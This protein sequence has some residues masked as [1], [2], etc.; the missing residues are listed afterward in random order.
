MARNRARRALPL[1]PVEGRRRLLKIAALVLG[2]VALL[3]AGAAV[4]AYVKLQRNIT[5]V[6]VA[7]QL[8]TERPESPSASPSTKRT[9]EGPLTV[10][11]FGDDTRSGKNGFVGGEKGKGRSD[12]ALVVHLNAARTRAT[13]VS[14]P[15][16]SMVQR[17]ECVDA[18]GSVLPGGLDMFNAAYTVG[19]P[20]C[21]IRTIEA[22]TGIRIDEYVVVDFDGFRK[23]VDA[24]GGVDVCVPTAIKDK[25]SGL[26]IPAGNSELDGDQALAFVRNRHGV[27]DGSDLSRIKMQQLF[28]TSLAAKVKTLDLVNLPRLYAFLDAS[29]SSLTTS[30]KLA[31]I[32]NLAELAS[33]V[34]EL[35]AS[36]IT[37]VTVPVGAY[38][39]DPNRVQ[40][41]P[42][43]E[44]L[45]TSI[46]KDKPLPSSLGPKKSASPKPNPSSPSAD[47]RVC[48]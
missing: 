3:G 5:T 2:I 13:V 46:K 36:K 15:R 32:P 30:P 17:P 35:P 21:S 31:K 45:W 18:D 16:D 29:T 24:V 8:G 38:A 23:I 43:A 12:T 27:G 20:A 14:I 7:S 39:P 37:M 41:T 4:A 19:G 44:K 40:W 6:D 9:F 42:E 10:A 1:G 33:D 11:V 25:D 28:L 26:D 47:A 34:R 22:L 48:G